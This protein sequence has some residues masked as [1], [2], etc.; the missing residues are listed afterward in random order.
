MKLYSKKR[1]NPFKILFALTILVGIAFVGSKQFISKKANDI[2]VAQIGDENIYK[3]EIERKL[4]DLF[5]SNK[6]AKISFDKLPDQV[7]ELFAREIFLD[8]KIIA[9]AKRLGIDNTADVKNAIETFK[10]QTIRQAYIN[11][12]I[13]DSISDQKIVEKF[14]EL[15]AEIENKVEYK[16]FQ[17][18]VKDKAT[19]E[20]ILRDFKAPKKPLKFSDAVKKYSVDAQSSQNNGE[21]P[22]RLESS[23]NKEILDFLKTS[24]KD[25]VSKPIEAEGLWYIVKLSDTKKN[26]PLEFESSKEYVRHLIKLSEVEKLNGKFIQDNKV[27]ILLKRSIE[28]PVEVKSNDEAPAQESSSE[29]KSDNAPVNTESN[30]N[31]QPTEQKAPEAQKVPESES[32]NKENL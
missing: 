18:V 29:E 16:Y 24:Q 22:Y 28:T 15:N 27:K 31:E 32:K 5:A 13:K 9:E 1:K 4:E 3:S 30:S 26:R 23:I 19:A 6:S 8:K 21:V 12:Q 14:N 20:N 10:T 17:I 25:E 2:L 11:S 7:I